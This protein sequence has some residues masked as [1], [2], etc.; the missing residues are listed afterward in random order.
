MAS[1]WYIINTLSGHE[2]KVKANLENRI[3]KKNLENIILQ[4][5]VPTI[6]VAEIKDGKRKTRKKKYLPGYVMI[7]MEENET[8]WF[9]VLSIPGV[10][11]FMGTGN[12]PKPLSSQEVENLFQQMGEAGSSDKVITQDFFDIGEHVKVTDGPFSNFNGVVEEIYSDKGR[13]RI[14]VEIFGRSTPVE[15]NFSQVGKI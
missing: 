10:A 13:L 9:E 12:T 8:A 2:N 6:E 11:K 5:K 3:K 1:G 4:V 7:E 14:R 15:L